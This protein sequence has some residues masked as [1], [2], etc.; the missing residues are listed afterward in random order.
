MR[1][2]DK[3]ARVDSF[4]KYLW[5]VEIELFT[6][7]LETYIDFNGYNFA[8]FTIKR[9]FFRSIYLVLCAGIQFMKLDFTESFV[10]MKIIEIT[11]QWSL[12][13]IALNIFAY[14]DSYFIHIS[15][16]YKVV[17]QWESVFVS[18]GMSLFWNL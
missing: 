11:T 16:I 18:N 17:A 10:S 8:R 4:E 2:A 1:L 6:A 15:K 3:G 9:R 7:T 14:K 5:S 13:F 12:I